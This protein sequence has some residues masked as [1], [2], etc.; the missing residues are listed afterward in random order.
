[1]IRYIV[2]ITLLGAGIL[3]GQLDCERSLADLD[4]VYK[5]GGAIE[6]VEYA[7]QVEAWHRADTPLCYATLSL[8][9]SNLFA[10]SGRIDGYTRLEQRYAERGLSVADKIPVALELYLVEH[11]RADLGV[12]AR[13]NATRWRRATLWA[14]AWQRIESETI[15]DFDFRDPPLVNVAPP[16][17][18]SPTAAGM[19]P[20]RI[21]DPLQR[22]LYQAAID[23]NR[24][25]AEICNTQLIL[26]RMTPR[27]V[28]EVER[29]FV[30]SFTNAQVG[31][32]VGLLST[33]RSVEKE[34]IIQ[35]VGS[36]AGFGQ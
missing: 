12:T 31:E 36:R 16:R 18:P 29:Y 2:P 28:S 8:A 6:L 20:E 25:K 10:G 4:S 19:S 24:K 23:Q 30:E 17:G 5:A 11:L 1:M 34:R 9:I 15:T 27:F 26:K 35:R 14:H 21:D 13:D 22:A 33:I 32:V 3:Y 7:S